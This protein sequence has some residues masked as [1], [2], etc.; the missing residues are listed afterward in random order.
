MLKV[1]WDTSDRTAWDDFHAAAAAPLQQHW[2]Y[3]AAL[4]QLGAT[5]H[6]AMVY[7][8][9]A[10]VACAQFVVRRVAGCVSVALCTR[11][12]VFALEPDLA[13]RRAIVGLIRRTAPYPRPRFTF[14]SPEAVNAGA[15]A[16]RW[17]VMT[18]YSTV[19]LDLTR[20]ETELRRA[21]AVK[22]RNRLVAAERSALAVETMGAKPAQYQW[23]LAHEET[24]RSARG[25]QA[26]P[27]AF[28]P[29][30]QQAQGSGGALLGLRA[31]LGRAPAAAMLF[32]VHGRAATYHIG[33]S[34][35]A[36]RELGAHNL[37]L[38]QAIL[39]LKARGVRRL[40]LGGVNTQSGAGVARFKLGTGG[41]VLTL[42]GTWL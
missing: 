4:A 2:A 7:D 36:G 20:T 28:L 32:L 12:P 37:L 30:W 21:L 14:I 6:R 15:Y 23:L 13:R 19:M 42:D 35:E 16:G 40:D 33:W 11:G 26:L 10:L 38:W 24:Q 18:G 31:D 1:T 29:A 17:R 8:G 34:G 3:G 5:C 39:R 25:Y 22:W 9:D 41:A 27:L